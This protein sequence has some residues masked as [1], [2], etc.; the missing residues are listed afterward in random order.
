MAKRIPITLAGMTYPTKKAAIAKIREILHG[1]EL[2][3]P[4]TGEDHQFLM[5]L[6]ER[7]PEA[8][9]KIGDGVDYF[10]VKL[11]SPVGWRPTSGFWIKRIDGSEM[12]F[13]YKSC[14]DQKTKTLEKQLYDACREAIREDL[15]HAKSWYFEKYQ[16]EDRKVVC[17]LSGEKVGWK[18][19]EIDHIAPFTFKVVFHAFLDILDATGNKIDAGWL[20]SRNDARLVTEFLNDDIRKM[21]VKFHNNFVER[22]QALRVISRTA[23]RHL[24][25]FKFE[26][27]QNPLMIKNGVM[28]Q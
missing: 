5:D 18:Q 10:K 20:T 8:L 21:W 26:G 19:A 22:N 13:S 25:R 4:I 12:D 2:E 28:L 14:L 15:M 17:E 11:N 24:T 3:T 7:H 1:N 16:D 27:A 23:H 9:Y 6:I